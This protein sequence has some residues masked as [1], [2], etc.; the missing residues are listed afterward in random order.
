VTNLI[1]TRRLRARRP[2]GEQ[3]EIELGIGQPVRCSDSEWKCSVV[4]SGLYDRLADQHGVDSWQALMLAQYLARY[5]LEEFVADGGQLWDV[6][7]GEAVA[8]IAELFRA[9][10][11]GT[12]QSRQP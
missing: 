12:P 9:G 1:A 7:T 8:N 10:V 6:E 4:L 2:Q 5:L 11:H 3:F